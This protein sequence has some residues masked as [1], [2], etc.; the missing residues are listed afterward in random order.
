MMNK[1]GLSAVVTNMIII[2]LVVVAIGLVWTLVRGL[3]DKSTNEFGSE[4]DCVDIKINAINVGCSDEGICSLTLKRNAG[5]GEIAGVKLIFEGSQG[6]DN[7]VWEVPGNIENLGTKSVANIATGIDKVS[8]VS[9][10]VYIYDNSGKTQL[11][12][13]ITTTELN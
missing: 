6:E 1:R 13:G 2:F 8:E 7:F 3:L 5:G 12:K 9:V 4:L 11:C 10:A